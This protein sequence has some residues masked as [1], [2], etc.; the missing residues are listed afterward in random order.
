MQCSPCPQEVYHL[1]IRIITAH[2][3]SSGSQLCLLISVTQRVCMT[4]TSGTHL[5]RLRFNRSGAWL[6]PQ[7]HQVIRMCHKVENHG[8]MKSLC[9][10]STVLS[11]QLKLTS[12]IFITTLR[13]QCYKY[14]HFIDREIKAKKREAICPRSGWFGVDLEFKPPHPGSEY[15]ALH[16]SAIMHHLQ[17]Q[18]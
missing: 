8:I 14:Y 16:C 2:I 12:L 1:V 9:V 18:S 13:R 11:T 7:A 4:L 17:R 10:L 5:Q 3:C 6:R 15:V